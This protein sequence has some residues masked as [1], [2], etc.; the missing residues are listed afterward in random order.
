MS[1]QGRPR[2][3]RRPTSG[4][5]LGRV[6]GAPVI[7]APSWL[8]V[9]GFLTWL[10]LPL[11]R[12][13]APALGTVATVAA[14]AIFPVLLAISVLLHELGH[15]LTARRLGVPVTE[16]VITLWGGHTQFD[17]EM[18]GPAAS[19]IVSA[20]GPVTNGVLAG[21]C[22]WG[23]EASEPGLAALLLGAGAIANGFVAGFNL[24]P[25]LPLDGGR[26]LEAVVWK[27]TGERARGTVAAG[28]VGRLLA[29]ALVVVM[30]GRPLLAGS[31]ADIVTAITVLLVSGFLWV[32]ASQAIRA[33]RMTRQAGVVDLLTLARPVVVVPPDATLADVDARLARTNAATADGRA[34]L[35]DAGAVTSD[36]RAP[37]STGAA[38][39]LA[40]ADGRP[41]A[42]LDET[43]AATVP[44]PLRPT[45]PVRA[46]STAVA[47]ESVV[48]D[49]RGVDA[50]R[51]MSR[52]QT[53]GRA[54]VLV[55]PA[56]HPP[57]ILGVVRVESVAQ[58]LGRRAAGPPTARP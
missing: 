13:A 22:W 55:D 50:V 17:R 19:A 12:S 37:P 8:V 39:V 4:L 34:R 54:A 46:V 24:L 29:V 36:L 1:T 10:F 38:V 44:P 47:P 27:A 2:S 51:A 18:R 40:D 35:T 57:R 43:V 6:G 30:I 3:A 33:G 31:Q 21:L 58:A 56:T 20:A 25:G 41:V 52:A 45:T 26:I 53:A 23:A 49:R 28:W 9:A 14:A 32:G 16:Y 11:V 5:V 42:L 7:L 15:G 48:S